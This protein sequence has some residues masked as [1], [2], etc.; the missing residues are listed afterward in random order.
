MSKQVS[1]EIQTRHVNDIELLITE[2]LSRKE[3]LDAKLQITNSEIDDLKAK[4]AELAQLVPQIKSKQVEENGIIETLQDQLESIKSTTVLED[5]DVKALKTIQ[6][7]LE[8]KRSDLKSLKW[9]P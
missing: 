3:S 6:S 4:L 1:L 9:M 5:Q 7:T 2:A 8:S